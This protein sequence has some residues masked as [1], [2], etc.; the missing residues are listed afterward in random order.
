MCCHQSA[1]DKKCGNA[2]LNEDRKNSRV[3][4]AHSPRRLYQRAF[5]SGRENT[6]SIAIFTTRPVCLVGPVKLQSKRYPSSALQTAQLFCRDDYVSR[7][8]LNQRQIRAEAEL[9]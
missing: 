5:S 2:C 7:T 8:N 9:R 6:F 4:H 3:A 1:C